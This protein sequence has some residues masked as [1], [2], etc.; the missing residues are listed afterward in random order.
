MIPQT[1]GYRALFL[2][3]RPSRDV[4]AHACKMRDH[5]GISTHTSLAGRDEIPWLYV[6]IMQFLLTRPSRDVTN[7]LTKQTTNMLFLLT[8]PSRDVTHSQT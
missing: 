6:V 1:H 7:A 2:L 8:R 4:T 5:A 3:T